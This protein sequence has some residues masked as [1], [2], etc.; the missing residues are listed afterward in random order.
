MKYLAYLALAG[1]VSSTK[2]SQQ[3]SLEAEYHS[4]WDQDKLAQLEQEL[5]SQKMP[6]TDENTHLK[7]MDL[8]EEDNQND[9]EEDGSN[10]EQELASNE[11]EM[12]DNLRER[13]WNF[14]AKYPLNNKLVGKWKRVG[15]YTYYPTKKAWI[16]SGHRTFTIKRNS[17]TELVFTSNFGLNTICTESG[18]GVCWVTWSNQRCFIIYSSR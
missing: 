5:D 18:P 13:D 11:N 4:D 3:T 6:L 10:H 7:E 12:D 8:S 1:L 16:N 2:I 14:K 15:F 17:K 9:N